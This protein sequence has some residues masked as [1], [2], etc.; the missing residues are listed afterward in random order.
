MQLLVQ[1]RNMPQIAGQKRVKVAK[2]SKTAS[3]AHKALSHSIT[4]LKMG[5]GVCTLMVAS[6]QAAPVDTSAKY[7]VS[8]GGV[9]I[10]NATIDFRDN[11]STYAVD[12]DADVA[13]V[14]ALVASGSAMLGSHGTS[15]GNALRADDFTFQTRTKA[16]QFNVG[17]QYAKGNA[18][19]FKVEPPLSNHIGRIALERKHLQGV[20]DPLG[21]F[22]LK[23]GA[24][25]ADLCKRR[26]KVFTGVERYD[27]AMSFA[28]KQNATSKRT[29]YQGPV[30][31][32]KMRYIPV[33]GHFTSSEVTGYLANSDRILVWYAPLKNS[34]YF[35]PYRVLLGTAAGDLSMV[36]TGL[37]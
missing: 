4:G 34:E 11:G 7:V 31:L 13:G 33:S 20:S 24:L 23:G 35:I 19:G 3:W 16:E 9:N 1:S 5:L 14:G 22:I 2:L 8:L 36:L 26:L 32:C 27:I 21:A 29:G 17:V 18:T 15:K 30:V 12:V 37:E 28:A 6:A 10:A 25:N